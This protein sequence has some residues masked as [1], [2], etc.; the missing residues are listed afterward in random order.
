MFF[1]GLDFYSFV[2]KYVSLYMLKL[3]KKYEYGLYKRPSFLKMKQKKIS[4]FFQFH[5]FYDTIAISGPFALV[6]Y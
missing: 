4:I 6:L 1:C 3:P 5:A 2:Q